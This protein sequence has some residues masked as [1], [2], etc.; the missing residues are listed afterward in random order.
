MRDPKRIPVL[1]QAI[2]EV[3]ER[4]PDLRFCQLVQNITGMNDSFYL[5]DEEFSRKLIEFDD[6]ISQVEPWQSGDKAYKE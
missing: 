2:K 5:E 3:W 4:H 1:L 6:F